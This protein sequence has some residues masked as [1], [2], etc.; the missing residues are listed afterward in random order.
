MVL[1]EANFL[2]PVCSSSQRKILFH[3]F[4]REYWQC[5]ECGLQG[6]Y[7]LPSQKQIKSYYQ[8]DF[9][10]HKGHR[11]KK[12]AGDLSYRAEEESFLL[13]F[14]EV[15]AK[16][17]KARTGLKTG[18]VLDIGCSLG[19]FLKVAQQEG[20]EIHGLDL[21][22]EAV[23]EARKR[24]GVKTIEYGL[25]EKKKYQPAF[26]DL[27]TVFQ[28][29]EHLRDPEAFLKEVYRLLKPGGLLLVSTPNTGGWQRLLMRSSW[30]AYR[31]PDHLYFF[32]AS[33]LTRL[34]K[35]SGYTLVETLPDPARKYR[36]DFIFQLLPYYFRQG[37]LR[38][39]VKRLG[40]Y[41][42]FL[43]RV[44]IPIP[45]DSLLVLAEK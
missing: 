9:W 14:A 41:L 12:V 4:K 44:L 37:W 26:F 35:N 45:L 32:T 11:E 20:W 3:R 43:K 33:S 28:T 6:C 34:A 5:L 19:Y 16:L 1:V 24:L 30:F 29:L 42:S 27:I 2:C 21:S 40:N 8:G 31:H 18:K 38:T 23:I 39:L 17:K 15:I 36:L 22:R 7:P 25:L 13:Y 10:R